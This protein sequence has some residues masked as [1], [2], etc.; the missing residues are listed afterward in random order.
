MRS[1]GNKERPTLT[2]TEGRRARA[3]ELHKKGWTNSR[4]AE[5]LG[6]SEP[7]VSHWVKIARTHG[8]AALR[9]RRP[10]GNRARLS[11]T[12]LGIIPK[13]LKYGPQQFGFEGDVWTCRRIAV[14]INQSLGVRYHPDH[15]RKMMH[16]FKWS[17]QKP[18]VMA[19]Q[20]NEEAIALWLTVTWPAIRERAENEGRTIIFV[21]ETAFYLCP[22]VT[23]TWSP[24]GQTPVIRAP[25]SHVHLSVIGGITY[26]GSLY[27]QVQAASFRTKGV[28]EFLRH[29][30]FHVPGNILI[31]WDGANIHRSKELA[32][33]LEMDTIRR[34]TFEHFPAYAPEVD[35]QE[36]VWRHLKHV[37][38]HNLTSH[39]LDELWVH[40]R[41]ATR[42]LRR[43]AGLLRRL[44]QHA[45]LL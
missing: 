42:R 39:S 41:A 27:I 38:L 22:T 18:V 11:K 7:A 19:S 34:M 4:I 29:I 45:R 1:P 6:V 10:R 14:A 24:T 40:V 16:A 33:F 9:R 25:T 17:F 28:I 21:D 31:V 5:A 23:R 32:S 3:W 36:Y 44:A 37:D 15:V 30:L 8:A 35:P 26:G 20:R 12:K 43:R 13:L 2:W